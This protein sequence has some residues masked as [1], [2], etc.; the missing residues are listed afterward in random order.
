MNW[1]PEIPVSK[2]ACG[3]TKRNLSR[4]PF[5]MKTNLKWPLKEK[6]AGIDMG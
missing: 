3:L 4:W 5:E 6:S 1:S 2:R